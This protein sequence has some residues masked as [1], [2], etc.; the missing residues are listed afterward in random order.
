M[1]VYGRIYSTYIQEVGNHAGRTGLKES[2]TKAYIYL[3]IL[4]YELQELLPRVVLD[5]LVTY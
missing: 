5:Y 1:P 4:E 2:S 3:N